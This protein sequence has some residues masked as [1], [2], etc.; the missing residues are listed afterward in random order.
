MKI[1][2][3]RH[4]HSVEGGSPKKFKMEALEALSES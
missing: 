4:Q 1:S 3:F 2:G